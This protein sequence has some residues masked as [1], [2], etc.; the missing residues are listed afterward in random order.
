MPT[1][2]PWDCYA[3]RYPRR[4]PRSR[5][6]TACPW[7]GYVRCYVSETIVPPPRRAAAEP[8]LPGGEKK[9]G[10]RPCCSGK[11]EAPTGKPWASRPLPM[12]TACPWDYYAR[13]YP[14]GRPPRSRMPT[15]CPWDC[16]A[17]RYVSEP[18][19]PPPRRAAAEPPLPGG[20]KKKGGAA[21]CSDKREAPTGK[22]WASRPCQC[23]R[24]AVGTVTFAA[25]PPRC[26]NPSAFP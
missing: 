10:R 19:V 24:L 22:P 4:P 6:P 9:K 21:V 5:M 23:P 25:P 8:P 26:G 13:R 20:E 17:R 15:A 2:C 12:P 3:R 16:Y 11:R 14:R 1:A 18:I 7:D